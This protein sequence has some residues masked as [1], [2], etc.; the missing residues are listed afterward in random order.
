[1][2]TD[3]KSTEMPSRVKA[4]TPFGTTCFVGLR[5]AD[6]YLQYYLI[7]QGGAAKLLSLLGLQTISISNTSYADILVGLTALGS[8]KQIFWVLNISENEMPTGQAFQ[9]GIANTIFAS[10]NAFLASWATSSLASTSGFLLSDASVT[11]ELS[12]N[13]IVGAAVAMYVLGIAI[14]TVSELQRKSFKVDAKNKGKPYAGGLFSFARHINYSGYAV[15]RAANALAAGGF[16]SAAAVFS[17]FTHNFIS[18]SIPALD[19]VSVRRK[20]VDISLTS[21]LV[22]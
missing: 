3:S 5:A 17:F 18:N 16:T 11:Q 19:K 15:W 8:L 4:S 10:V 7:K 12:K 20:D 1:M 13:S 22:L 9:I 6:I 21:V 2:M 14:E